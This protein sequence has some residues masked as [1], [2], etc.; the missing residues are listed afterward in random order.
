MLQ[1][2]DP[3]SIGTLHAAAWYIVVRLR[4]ALF[5]LNLLQWDPE[6]LK[7]SLHRFTFD[8]LWVCVVPRSRPCA[9][10]P[11][12]LW[13]YDRFSSEGCVEDPLEPEWTNVDHYQLLLL[14]MILMFISMIDILGWS[15]FFF[16]EHWV[17]HSGFLKMWN[18]T[19]VLLIQLYAQTNI[20]LSVT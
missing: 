11:A 3:V 2:T 16:F 1:H 13:E 10:S 17:L 20:S 9:P 8:C 7:H 19:C 4:N 6:I 14:K 12:S 18:V 15:P 5:K